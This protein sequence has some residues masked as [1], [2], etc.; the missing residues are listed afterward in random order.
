MIHAKK[1]LC[2][3]GVTT[4]GPRAGRRHIGYGLSNLYLVVPERFKDSDITE[5]KGQANGIDFKIFLSSII[6]KVQ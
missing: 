4:I 6:R 1:V 5:Y 2:F 3:V